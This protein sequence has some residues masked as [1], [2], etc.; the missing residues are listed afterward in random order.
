MAPFLDRPVVTLTSPPVSVAVRQFVRI[1]VNVKVPLAQPQGYGGVVIRDS[2]GGEPLQFRITEAI[3]DWRR[4]FLYRRVPADG[5]LTV[6][7]GLAGFGEALFDDL[8]IDRVEA[9]ADVPSNLA[10][11]PRTPSASL[12]RRPATP[13]R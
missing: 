6:T 3:P 2:L 1:S 8:R 7:L 11:R 5:E 9:E 10:R 13:R 4:V 12:P